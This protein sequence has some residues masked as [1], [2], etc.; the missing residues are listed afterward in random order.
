MVETIEEFYDK[1]YYMHLVNRLKFFLLLWAKGKYSRALEEHLQLNPEESLEKYSE[2]MENLG[3]L[4]IDKNI[5]PDGPNKDFFLY[6]SDEN[7]KNIFK[8]VFKSVNFNFN[9]DIVDLVSEDRKNVDLDIL[10][11]MEFEIGSNQKFSEKRLFYFLEKSIS[12]FFTFIIT[13][14]PVIRTNEQNKRFFSNISSQLISNMEEMYTSEFSDIDLEENTKDA[15]LKRVRDKSKREYL[16][17][18]FR[19]WASWRGY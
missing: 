10:N 6:I 7:L 14:S 9:Q 3:F 2:I 16:R 4:T 8:H 5:S 19:V 1:F 11:E 15:Q 13:L 12:F 18:S 17:E